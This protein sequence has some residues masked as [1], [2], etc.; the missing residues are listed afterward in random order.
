M[1]CLL[2]ACVLMHSAIFWEVLH[3]GGLVPNWR[4]W[5][6][7]WHYL[8][9]DPLP[10]LFILTKSQLLD[11][12]NGGAR[13]WPDKRQRKHPAELPPQLT[14]L[15]A[16]ISP[17]SSQKPFKLN[18]PPV[19]FLCVSLSVLLTSSHYG[20]FFLMFPTSCLLVACSASWP[21]TY[22]ILFRKLSD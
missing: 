14:P 15:K 9:S 13:C 20:F 18:V 17:P 22:S 8:I 19:F 6:G 3:S 5:V 10:V 1:A 16:K 12:T 11:Y 2:H 7:P 4:K 21:M